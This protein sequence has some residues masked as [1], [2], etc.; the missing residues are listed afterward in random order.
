MLRFKKPRPPAGYRAKARAAE[1]SIRAE[2]A[3]GQNPTFDERIWKSYKAAFIAAQHDK[4]AYCEQYAL[5]HPGAVEHHAPKSE[6][7]QL[8]DPGA[9]HPGTANVVGRKTAVISDVGY[10]WLA[11]AWHNWLFACE[12]CNS[13]W[14]RCLF[15]VRE[16]FRVVP[17]HY[18][19]D[20]TPLLL[21]PFGRTD[22]ILHLSFSPLGQIAPRNRSDHGDAT[23]QTCG[24][25]RESLR[26]A[27]EGIAGFAHGFASRV[28]DKLHG[29]NYP[30]ALEAV[31]DLLALGAERR[32]HAGMVR[33]IVWDRLG[34]PWPDLKRLKT[35]LQAKVRRGSS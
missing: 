27:R 16:S 21:H 30:G 35:R 5:N 7:H 13:G 15:P 1:R 26:R 33:A 19:A 29:D 3:A 10:W 18:T 6:V 2:M 17:P 9:E 34:R 25:D 31:N 23:I 28:L 22:P 20:E 11:Y 8:I 4:C 14:K 24:L 32:A 12:R